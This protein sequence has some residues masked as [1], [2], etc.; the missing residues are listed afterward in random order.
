MFIELNVKNGYNILR[1]GKKKIN[2]SKRGKL[3]ID[4]QYLQI[5]GTGDLLSLD[6]VLATLVSTDCLYVTISQMVPLVSTV[7]YLEKQYYCI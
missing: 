2:G 5:L 3:V 7:Y 4:I 1:V 6:A